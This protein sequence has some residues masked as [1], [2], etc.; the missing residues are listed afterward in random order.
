MSERAKACPQCGYRAPIAA[1]PVIAFLL[2]GIFV[3]TMLWVWY[4]GF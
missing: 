4:K 1:A 2:I 3:A